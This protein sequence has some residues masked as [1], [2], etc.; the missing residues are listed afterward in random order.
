VLRAASEAV[1]QTVD[2][3]ARLVLDAVC[4]LCLL[5]G[6]AGLLRRTLRRPIAWPPFSE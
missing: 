4:G 6:V 2:D 3:K 1:A 5:G